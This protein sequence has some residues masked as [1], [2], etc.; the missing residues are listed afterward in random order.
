[1]MELKLISEEMIQSTDGA[2]FKNKYIKTTILQKTVSGIVILK[3]VLKE[4]SWMEGCHYFSANNENKIISDLYITL[5]NG[6]DN[7]TFMMSGVNFDQYEVFS[8]ATE[9]ECRFYFI[10]VAEN[11]KVI[12][13]KKI[14]I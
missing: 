1:M 9:N 6:V 2:T 7:I 3:F 5:T 14:N 11:D 10:P 8:K 12:E 13:E 4:D